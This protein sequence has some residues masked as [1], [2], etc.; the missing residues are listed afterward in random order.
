MSSDVAEMWHMIT[1]VIS[2]GATHVSKIMFE[3]INQ[4]VNGMVEPSS[5]FQSH[6]LQV[7]SATGSVQ[8]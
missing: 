1:A 5:S 7:G 2:I 4:E 3:E 6:Q 8:I